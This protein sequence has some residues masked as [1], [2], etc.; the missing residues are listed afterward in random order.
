[1]GKALF[2][3]CFSYGKETQEKAEMLAIPGDA[4]PEGGHKLTCHGQSK[5][6]D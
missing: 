6:R 1:M 3:V 5:S 4:A 2:E